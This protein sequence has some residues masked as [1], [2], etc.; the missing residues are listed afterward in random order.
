[1]FSY[2]I[3]SK[4]DV[5]FRSFYF[6]SIFFS[7]AYVTVNVITVHSTFLF[8]YR[9]SSVLSIVLIT[10]TWIDNVPWKVKKKKKRKIIIKICFRAL[11]LFKSENELLWWSVLH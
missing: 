2:C 9:D 6:F 11:L 5:I 10:K 4:V 3:T 1:M 7:I 8:I